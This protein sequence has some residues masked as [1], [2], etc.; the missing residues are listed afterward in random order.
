MYYYFILN[1][2][3]Y[4]VDNCCLFLYYIFNVAVIVK[5]LF[6]LTCCRVDCRDEVDGE[7][8]NF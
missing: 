5:L 6:L 1:Y 4:D 3:N 2:I 7:I 8:G